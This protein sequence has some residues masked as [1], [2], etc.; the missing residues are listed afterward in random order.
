MVDGRD[1]RRRRSSATARL[2]VGH[3]EHRPAGSG[4]GDRGGVHG[5]GLA[6]PGRGDQRPHR[7]AR[8][9][10]HAARPRP[11]RRPAVPHRR[12]PARPR[13]GPATNVAVDQPVEPLEHAVLQRQVRRRRPLGGV[14]TA[15]GRIDAEANDMRR[16]R[17]TRPVNARISATVSRPPP[18]AATFSITW[19]SPKRESL[20]HSPVSGCTNAAATSSNV[21][22]RDDA[23]TTEHGVLDGG[24]V[25]ETGSRGFVGPAVA[26]PFGGQA[27][28]L[29]RAGWPATP[30]DR[31]A[32]APPRSD[33]RRRW[34]P[35]GRRSARSASR[36]PAAG[37]G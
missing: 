33:T 10:Q 32:S 27:A 16:T 22:A 26:Q 4:G 11:D 36:T 25:A 37:P 9:A 7:R 29:G 24:G 18:T 15:L 23:G 14:R 1:A 30:H 34:L 13:P 21:T 12:S 2:V 17:G 5:G 31:P 8:A 19:A 20:A 35:G 3:P 6:E 28:V